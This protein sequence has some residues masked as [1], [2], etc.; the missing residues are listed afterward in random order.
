MDQEVTL[1]RGALL[2]L[3]R[4]AHEIQPDVT[5]EEI[6]HFF[7]QR[8]VSVYRNRK[9]E[10]PTG[11]MLATIGDWF[12]P[13]RVLERREEVRQAAMACEALKAQLSEMGIVRPEPRPIDTGEPEIDQSM[14]SRIAEVGGRKRLR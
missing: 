10:N 8:A 4:T 6:R 9:L 14:R 12:E 5:G 13:R 7:H 11:L 2:K 3:W 1:D